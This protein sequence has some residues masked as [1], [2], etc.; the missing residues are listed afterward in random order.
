MRAFAVVL[1]LVGVLLGTVDAQASDWRDDPCVV[2]ASN[3]A[4]EGNVDDLDM[5]LNL[6]GCEL[7]TG[8]VPSPQFRSNIDGTDLPC[9]VAANRFAHLWLDLGLDLSNLRPET[10]TAM[11]SANDCDTGFEDWS[12]DV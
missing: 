11:M 8:G 6:I 9:N 1:G 10:I 2:L 5:R 4:A 7:D 3:V 12:W